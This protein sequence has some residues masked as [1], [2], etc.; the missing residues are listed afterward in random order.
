MDRWGRTGEEGWGHPGQCAHL[1]TTNHSFSHSD[2][3]RRHVKP[4]Q[5]EPGIKLANQRSPVCK[6]R[7]QTAL[8]LFFTYLFLRVS[9]PLSVSAWICVSRHLQSQL[10]FLSKTHSVSHHR[11]RWGWSGCEGA[12]RHPCLL[13]GHP[14]LLWG[15]SHGV[16]SAHRQNSIMSLQCERWD[17][18][19]E[20]LDSFIYSRL[21]Q[22]GALLLGF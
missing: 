17:Y 14:A 1:Q 3:D 19:L 6:A 12:C 5:N 22:S 7:A 2:T 15:S 9:K 21:V 13:C 8:V 11:W 16:T 18:F 10:F 20:H 4:I